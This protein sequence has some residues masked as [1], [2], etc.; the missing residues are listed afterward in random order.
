MAMTRCLDCGALFRKGPQPDGPTLQSRCTDCHRA[1]DRRRR[2][3]PSQR[4]YT[5]E[6]RRNRAQILADHPVCALCGRAAAS[7]LDHIVPLHAGGTNALENLRP[8]CAP[9][10]IRRG[11]RTRRKQQ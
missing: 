2:P 6:Y 10:N 11:N 4:G 7:T 5:A 1:R 8:A 9:C 3:S